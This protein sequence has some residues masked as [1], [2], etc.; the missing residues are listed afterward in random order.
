MSQGL[1][2]PA[3]DNPS[4]PVVVTSSSP[5]ADQPLA[6]PSDISSS[7]TTPRRTSGQNLGD[8]P[9]LRSPRLDLGGFPSARLTRSR[10]VARSH[11]VEF[12]PWWFSSTPPRGG[13]RFDL[14]APRGT[15][16][17]ADDLSTAVRERL[18]ET[19]IA[20]G[21][22]S[23]VMADSFVVSLFHPARDYRCAHIGVAKAARFGVTRELGTCTPR[24]YPL[25]RAW[26]TG[27]DQAGYEGIRYG[28]RFAPGPANAWALFG[29]AGKGEPPEPEI[30]QVIPGREA[31]R[32]I[33]VN[34]LPIPRSTA[35]TVITNPPDQGASA[36]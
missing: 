26:A 23:G 20:A 27:F 15:C 36:E 29:P 31:C 14:E 10:L 9:A 18:R 8:I 4:S 2:S 25:S 3:T 22:V 34:V 17:V 21:V 7:P 33:G 19:L 1:S 16:Y 11:R 24:H 5:A 6:P 28:A 35:L 13:G 30:D 32:L 12:D